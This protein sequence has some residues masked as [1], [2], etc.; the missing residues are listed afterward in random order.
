MSIKDEINVMIANQL[1]N[2]GLNNAIDSEKIKKSVM[3]KLS[4]IKNKQNNSDKDISEMQN[5][6][7][8]Q[9]PTEFPKDDSNTQPQQQNQPSQSNQPQ[10]QPQQQPTVNT[11]QTQIQQQT[12]NTQKVINPSEQPS[13]PKIAL[14]E[15]PYFLKD[16]KPEDIF[17]YDYNELS[18][19]GENLSTKPFKLLN[20][21]DEKKSMKDFWS[22]KGVTKADVYQSKFEKIGQITF[23]YRNGT[24]TF[25]EKRFEPDFEVQ[26]QYKENPYASDPKMEVEN[27]IKNNLDLEKV[28]SDVVTN[29]VKNYFLTNSER[30]EN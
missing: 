5:P 2:K 17:V 24:S 7:I 6:K 29:I 30:A 1:R 23:D 22:E 9:G 11:G 13:Q 27:Y 12:N 19:G 28:V 3:E 15:Q 4:Q 21:P 25:I 18:V 14:P 10:I 20:N 8:A 26:Q 16:V